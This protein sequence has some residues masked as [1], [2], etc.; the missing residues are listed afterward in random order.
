M[1]TYVISL[2]NANNRRIHIDNEFSSKKINFHYFDAIEPHQIEETAEKLELK[3]DRAFLTQGEIGCLLSHVSL[4]HK[5][6]K[7]D[8]EY[9][10]IFEDDIYLAND[11]KEFLDAVDWIPLGADIIKIEAFSSSVMVELFSKKKVLKDRIIRRLK[12]R[13]LGTGGYILS[14]E[15]ANTL[16]NYVRHL[17]VLSPI[18][19]IM[20]EE[21][22]FTHKNKIYQ[23]FP[24]LC[25]QDFLYNKEDTKLESGLQNERFIRQSKLLKTVEKNK[26]LIY[27]L[28]R[29][30][31]RLLL[32]VYS[33]YE[34]IWIRA[35]KFK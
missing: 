32:Q 19:N 8:I 17:P 10:A 30:L 9:M 4:W 16:L 26:S 31:G 5:M 15:G 25:I 33:L 29:E 35:V 14:K 2:V 12:S 1:D 23:L 20:F 34:K 3:I 11:T 6:I 27:K 21:Y 22:M 13:H 7:E 24:A 28:K 18:D